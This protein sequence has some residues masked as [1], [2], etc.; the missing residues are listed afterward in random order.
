MTC[1]RNC[2]LIVIEDYFRE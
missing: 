1:N 2:S